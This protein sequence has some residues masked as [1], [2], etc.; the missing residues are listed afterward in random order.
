VSLTGLNEGQEIESAVTIGAEVTAANP[1]ASVRFLVDGKSVG[2]DSA[3]P[4]QL[5]LDPVA[6]TPGAHT[7][8]VE[9]A[10]S[11]GA[12]GQA[13]ISFLVAAPVGGGGGGGIPLLPLLLVL[14]LVVLGGAG[15]RYLL[16]RRRRVSVPRQAVQV[17]LRPWSNP[18]ASAPPAV[19]L[20]D[21]TDSVADDPVPQTVSE[22]RGKLTIVSGPG[23]GQEFIVGGRPISIGS[24]GW[25]AIVLPDD[26]GRIG[27]EEARAWVHHSNR[28]IFHR[29]TRLSVLASEGAS[30]GWMILQDGD[31]VSIGSCRLAFRLLTAQSEE[32]RAISEALKGFS[33][34]PEDEAAG[35]EGAFY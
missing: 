27:L 35:G 11:T 10:D 32:E 12:V 22:P 26:D 16:R 6:F 33:T 17:R 19:T 8:R 13:D 3:P 29:L 23:A 28:L 9:A 18:N 34:P 15:G 5:S 7:L 1:L 4:F 24:A 14:L 21:W 31:E 2:E 25:C 30:G 20:S